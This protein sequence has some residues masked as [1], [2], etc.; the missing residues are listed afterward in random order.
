MSRFYTD[1]I[2][3][4]KNG[5]IGSNLLF[6]ATVK[7]VSFSFTTPAAGLSVGDIIEVGLLPQ[8]SVPAADFGWFD[9]EAMGGGA[10]CRSGTE[11]QP[12]IFNPGGVAID[13]SAAGAQLGWPN[14]SAEGA[15]NIGNI[16]VKGT[17]QDGLVNPL[18]KAVKVILTVAG[19]GWA[20]NKRV[21]G[22]FYYMVP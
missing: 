1:A 9:F 10:T 16:I 15:A 7:G 12:D 21:T 5:L 22:Q 4:A 18:S 13:V 2:K 14:Q 8:G 11:D 17:F 19:A 6:S 20:G 3:D